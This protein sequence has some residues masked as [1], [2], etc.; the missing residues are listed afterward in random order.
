[1]TKCDSI[2][3]GCQQICGSPNCPCESLL[4][5]GEFKHSGK[6][7]MM[8]HDVQE[9]VMYFDGLRPNAKELDHQDVFLLDVY[10][11]WLAERHKKT[12]ATE[13]ELVRLPKEMILG[14]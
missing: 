13:V 5:P 9:F 6:L 2:T 3:C 1:M 12:N 4:E 8:R 10:D 14:S 11:L 7:L